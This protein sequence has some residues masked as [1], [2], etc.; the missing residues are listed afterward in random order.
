MTHLNAALTASKEAVEQLIEAG[1]RSGPV[2]GNSPRPASGCGTT[3]FGAVPVEDY[4]RFMEIHTRHHGRQIEDGSSRRTDL[5][6]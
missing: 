6:A 2:A 3:I 1:E 5:R 4:V